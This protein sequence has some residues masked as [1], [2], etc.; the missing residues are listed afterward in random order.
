MDHPDA[1]HILGE[2]I[3]RLAK[4]LVPSADVIVVL[5]IG[6]DRSIGDA[7]GPLIGSELSDLLDG[8]TVLGTLDEPVHAGN[9]SSTVERVQ[10]TFSRPFIIAVDACLG[11]QE[12][13]GTLTVGEGSLK[14]GAGVNKALPAVGDIFLHGVVNVGGFMEYFVL[15]NTR[16]GFVARMARVA[17]AGI[18][19]G[20]AGLMAPNQ[21]LRERV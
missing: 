1:P 4:P 15:Q 19:V 6:T 20:L 2:A 5:C 18:R 10:A 7:L 9:L 3:V 13:V 12:S 21:S 11:R 8:A 16:L 14:P 17:A